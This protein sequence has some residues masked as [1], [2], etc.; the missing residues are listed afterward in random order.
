MVQGRR[1]DMAKRLK[2]RKLRELGWT[3][4]RIAAL[5]G[6]SIQAVSRLANSLG[7]IKSPDLV[8]AKCRLA[9]IENAGLKFRNG[10][11]LCL[12]CLKRTKRPTFAVRLKAYRLSRGWTQTDLARRVGCGLQMIAGY[13]QNAK[14][15][16]YDMLEKLVRVLGQEFVN[17]PPL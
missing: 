17:E 10:S 16:M 13:E 14:K 8:C 1:P 12:A 5:M 6:I 9:I 2:A 11:C 15:P 3:N 7:P 4:A